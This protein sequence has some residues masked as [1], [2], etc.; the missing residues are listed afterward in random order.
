MSHPHTAAVSVVVV[1]YRS[2]PALL[3][4]L[5]SL[6]PEHQGELEVIVVDNGDGAEVEQAARL[7]F[8][9]TLSP[10]ANLGYAAGSNLGAGA[11]AG[12]VLV[13]T[14]PDTV[15]AP[16]AIRELA[17]A[18]ADEPVAIAMARLRLLDRPELLNSSGNMLHV[19][20]IA[21]AGGYGERADTVAEVADVAY[22]SG[23]AMA[24]RAELFRALG[25]FTEELFMYQEDLD[26]GWRARLTGRRIVVTPRAD[27]Y[28][29]YEFGRHARK[30][31]FL[32]RNR[33]L[34]VLSA[35]SGRL[36]LVLAPVLVSAELA[37]LALAAREGWM[38]EK[39][40]GW[41]W[42]ARHARWLVRHRAA[43]QR[44]R[45]IPD[46]ALA[47]LLTPTIDPAMI[48]VPRAVRLANP[49]LAAYWSLARRAL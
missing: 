41:A 26:L 35:Y 8:V 30:N 16:G 10:G 14:N 11:A 24:I 1:S 28:H 23:A 45:R 37:M 31:Y 43:T 7:P 21:W 46:R 17:D 20:G 5:G 47:D 33:L 32:E 12:D 22:P 34:F 19:S 25:G 49:L 44:L 29:D 42:C 38:R 18:L 9:R 48:A 4:C 40:A 39:L 13:F 6:A 27:V 15:A 3:R 2:G 36:L